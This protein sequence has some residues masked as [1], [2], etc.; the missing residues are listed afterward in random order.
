MGPAKVNFLGGKGF[1]ITW[2]D[3]LHWSR[4]NCMI[5]E[6]HMGPVLLFLVAGVIG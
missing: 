1:R 3:F 4:A 5:G 6:L 2:A